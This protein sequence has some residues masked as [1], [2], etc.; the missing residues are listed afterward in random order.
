[1]ALISSY[2]SGGNE[3][4]EL[5]HRM[6][7]HLHHVMLRM[8][9]EIFT[10]VPFLTTKHDDTCRGCVPGKC[11]KETF[12][13]SNNRDKSVLGLIHSDIY[14]PMSTRSINGAK[15]FVTFIDDHSR[16]AWIYFLRTKDEVFDQFKEF[17]VLVENLTGNEDQD[18]VLKK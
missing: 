12:F 11:A 18:I 15:Y 3:L 14:G 2:V 9:K 13:G 6:M 7:G 4:N 1:M 10:V 8:L 16:K 17:K 5:W